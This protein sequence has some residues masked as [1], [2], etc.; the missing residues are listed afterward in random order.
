MWGA[1]SELVCAYVSALSGVFKNVVCSV[2]FFCDS[3][4]A[5][6]SLRR[7][8]DLAWQQGVSNPL[9]QA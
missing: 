5:M 3:E 4:N 6:C 2:L 9:G 8:W 1:A 7:K